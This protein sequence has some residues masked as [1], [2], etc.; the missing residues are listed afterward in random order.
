MGDE[1]LQ[2]YIRGRQRHRRYGHVALNGGPEQ[3]CSSRILVS[4]K[5]RC[6]RLR[7]ERPLIE[8]LDD[9]MDGKKRET[10]DV[11]VRSPEPAFAFRVARGARV[12][13]VAARE[14]PT[15]PGGKSG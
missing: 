5:R 12:L 4:K 1:L 2:R 9:A 10:H 14:V 11:F 13:G 3:R 6:T 7:I 15:D 8:D